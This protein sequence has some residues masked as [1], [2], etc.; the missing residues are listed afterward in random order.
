MLKE[1]QLLLVD[2]QQLIRESLEIILDMNPYIDVIGLAE[3]GQK[4]IDFCEQNEP[5]MILMDIH[6]PVMNGVE[7][8]R[9]I[10][11]RWPHI[12]VIILT[13]FKEIEYVMNALKAGAEGYLLKAISPE[14]VTAGVR[15]VHHGGTLIP[16]GMALALIQQ[17]SSSLNPMGFES[18]NPENIRSVIVNNNYALSEREKDVLLSVSHGLNNKEIAEKL[19]LSEGTVKN[20]ISN[21]YSKLDVRDRVQAAKKALDEKIV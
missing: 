3:D 9:V 4:A 10:K 14:D 17:N 6:M 20:Y 15:L 18:K 2:D 7:A 19:F 12:K 1:I 5:N 13:T 21:I 16:Q 8:T 11:K